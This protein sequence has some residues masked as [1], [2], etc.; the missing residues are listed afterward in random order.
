MIKEAE[1]SGGAGFNFPEF[2]LCYVLGKTL[3]DPEF[4]DF[5]GLHENVEKYPENFTVKRT[6]ADACR[7]EL[8]QVFKRESKF[9]GR[10]ANWIWD[11]NSNLPCDGNNYFDRAVPGFMDYARPSQKSPV[12]ILREFK[13]RLEP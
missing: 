11:H 12:E 2:K 6:H 5:V 4:A 13:G 10:Y 8:E 1:Q 9:I 7:I 3:A